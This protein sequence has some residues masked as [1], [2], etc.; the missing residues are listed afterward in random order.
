[1]AKPYLYI[2]N[3]KCKVNIKSSTSVFYIASYLLST[4]ERKIHFRENWL[5]VWG[6]WG[7]CID[8]KDLGSKEK[9]FLGAKEFSLR[10]LGR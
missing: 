2:D 9:Y 5:M 4:I 6:I 7:E 10:N 3:V 8:F 1:M